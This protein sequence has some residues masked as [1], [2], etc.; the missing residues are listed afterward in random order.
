MVKL[1]DIIYFKTTLIDL[2]IDPFARLDFDYFYNMEKF[3]AQFKKGPKFK[4]LRDIVTVMETRKPVKRTDYSQYET[5]YIHLVPR[6]IK[7]GEL[8]VREP[9]Y[10][11]PEKGEELKNFRLDTDDILISIS[12]NVGDSIIFED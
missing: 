7:N 9:I 2:A 5:D 10:L 8:S 11:T 3:E 1:A 4:T 6:D 12:S